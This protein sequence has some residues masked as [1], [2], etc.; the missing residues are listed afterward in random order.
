[1]RFMKRFVKSEEG[2]TALEYALIIGLVSVF[3][4]TAMGSIAPKI[5]RV[6][7][8]IGTAMDGT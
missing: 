8:V 3:L 6:F 7:G 2:V 4:I 1:M 5:G